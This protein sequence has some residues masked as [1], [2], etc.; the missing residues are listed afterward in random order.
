MS[1]SRID[2]N[3]ETLHRRATDLMVRL[4]IVGLL[5]YW[6]FAIFRPFLMPF[7]WGVVLAV[8]LRPLYAGIER[9][10]G[11]RRKLAATLLI[12]ACLVVV[13]IPTFLL[14]GSLVDGV[15][16]V[17]S[18]LEAGDVKIPPAPER[19]AQ[20]PVVGPTIYE[21]WNLASTNLEAVMKRFAPQVKAFGKW[22]V[23]LAKQSAMAVLVTAVAIVIAGFLLVRRE[24]AATVALDIGSRIAGGAGADFIRL[25][26]QTIGTVAKGVVGVAAIQAVLA[27][28]GLVLAGVPGAGLWSLLVLILAVAQLPPLLVLGP[29]ILY[30]VAADAG[31]TTIVLFTIWSLFV[32]VVDGL[33]KPLLLGRGS[34]SP[35]AVILIG[36]IGGLILHGL[37]GLFIGAVVFS[38]GFRLF[39]LWMRQNAQEGKA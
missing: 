32:S 38:T 1:E 33:L 29:A 2:P 21:T 6:C 3:Q 28:V 14:A 20:W 15:R 19:V 16:S 5:A 22:L 25:A 23:V 34:E 17:S 37:I 9:A 26:G 12:L 31:M 18:H 30:L 35:V 24:A 7:V 27:A 8:G 13:A 11:G 39:G 4:G 36:A 10:A